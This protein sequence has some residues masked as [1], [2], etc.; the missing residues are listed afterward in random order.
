MIFLSCLG[1]SAHDDEVYA[2]LINFLSCLGGS[3][4]KYQSNA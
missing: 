4:P 1:G 3:A 2:S